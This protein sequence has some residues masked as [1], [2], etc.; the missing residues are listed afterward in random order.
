[1]SLSITSVFIVQ[2]NT[3]LSKNYVAH[4]VTVVCVVGLI[5]EKK[6]VSLHSLVLC[7]YEISHRTRIFH[8]FAFDNKALKTFVEFQICWKRSKFKRCWIWIR[9]LSHLWWSELFWWI[10]IANIL[11]H[12]SVDDH[13]QKHANWLHLLVPSTKQHLT[14]LIVWRIRV[15]IIRTVSHCNVYHNRAR[16]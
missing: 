2:C 10:F 8:E 14:E 7:A 6:Q 5:W 1:M 15:E 11:L 3:S 12:S 4:S 16:S 13:W 9:S